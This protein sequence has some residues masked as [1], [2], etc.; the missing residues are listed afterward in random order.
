[1]QLEVKECLA[2]ILGE[3]S[4]DPSSGSLARTHRR[5]DKDANRYYALR[6]VL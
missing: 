3:G 6:I 2:E 1:M 5:S 4:T